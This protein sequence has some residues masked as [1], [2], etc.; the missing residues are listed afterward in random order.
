MDVTR[1]FFYTLG[2]V[3][4]KQAMYSFDYILKIILCMDY[5]LI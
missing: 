4:V 5:A 3:E 2:L 1:T